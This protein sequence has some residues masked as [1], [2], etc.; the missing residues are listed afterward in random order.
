MI[1]NAKL[2]KQSKLKKE[3]QKRELL[4]LIALKL[5]KNIRADRDPFRLLAPTIEWKQKLKN[6]D[7]P[8]TTPALLDGRPVAITNMQ[9]L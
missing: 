8:D 5:R 6:T 9:R 2:K 3:Q 1:Q 7:S 4:E